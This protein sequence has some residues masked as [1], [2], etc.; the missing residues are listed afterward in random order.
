MS[1]TLQDNETTVTSAAREI[2]SNQA[3][4]ERGVGVL[5]TAGASYF[6]GEVDFSLAKVGSPTGYLSAQVYTVDGSDLP[7]VRQGES[8]KI[9]VSTL[10]AQAW[11]VF[12]F[13]SPVSLTSGTKYIIM[14]ERPTTGDAYTGD[15][16]N[17]VNIYGTGGNTNANRRQ[18]SRSNADAYTVTDGDDIGFKCYDSPSTIAVNG[19]SPIRG[20]LRG[21]G[22]R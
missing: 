21:E 16:S 17:H 9:D 13:S 5:F 12:T 3:A 19:R 14:C 2:Y 15:G 7:N 1:G 11:A 22:L 10:G 18:N 8:A 20:V 6:L 4:Q